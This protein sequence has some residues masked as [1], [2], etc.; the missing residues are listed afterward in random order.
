MV[1]SWIW[2]ALGALGM[3]ALMTVL[4]REVSSQDMLSCGLGAI[5]AVLFAAGNGYRQG[6]RDGK[7][8]KESEAP[9]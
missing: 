6:Y 5:V 4:V 2:S 8:G 9:P 7:A 1:P 3:G